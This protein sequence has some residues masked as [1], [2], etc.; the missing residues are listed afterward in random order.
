MLKPFYPFRGCCT[1][2]PTDPDRDGIFEGLNGNNHCDF[3]DVVLY[4][5]QMEWIAE[6]EPVS[7]FD[8]NGDGRIDFADIVMSFGEI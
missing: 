5:N 8:L 4:F 7:A 6:N 3:A 2:L 1:L